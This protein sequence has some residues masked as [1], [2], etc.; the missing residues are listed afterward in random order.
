LILRLMLILAANGGPGVCWPDCYDL[1]T[2]PLNRDSSGSSP[3]DPMYFSHLEA[4]NSLATA[5]Q[6]QYC[7]IDTFKSQSVAI[8]LGPSHY[9]FGTMAGNVRFMHEHF[10]VILA[11]KLHGHRFHAEHPT[12]Q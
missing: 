6:I 2:G 8:I 4:I 5:L 1:L 3:Y 9:L 7:P 12:L 10:Y 11:P